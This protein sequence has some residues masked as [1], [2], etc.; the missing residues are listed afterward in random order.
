MDRHRVVAIGGS[1]GAVNDVKH[2]L[3][4]LPADL[5]AAVFIVVHV[6]AQGRNLLAGAFDGCGPL[7][8]TT[9]TDG[10]PVKPG[11]VYVAPA[12]QHLLV[13]DDVIRLGR[14]PREN[15]ARPSV[16]ALFRSVAL[17]Y[18]ARAIGLVI[19]GNLNDGAAGLAAIK[20]RGGVTAVQNPSDAVAPDMPL[21]ALE[22]SDVDYRAPTG[23]L[24][25]LL[26]SLAQQ[27]PGP[28]LPGSRALELEVDIALGR[29]C[30]STAIAEI[31]D[32]SPI[33]C[34]A[35]GGVL[36]EIK[37]PPL[38]YRC[39]VGHGY[40]GEA[41]AHEQ[42]GSIDEAVRV[43]LRI[44]DERATLTDRMAR[45]AQ[46]AGRPHSHRTLDD[47]T[48]ELRGYADVLRHAALKLME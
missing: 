43:A 32:V 14:G 16:D 22:A 46:A 13:V 39:Q 1:T 24:A 30:L 37:E 18:G 17:T 19:T 23:E 26:A 42:E 38:R 29:P 15:M 4:G 11:H 9:A 7:P 3:V 34:P 28:E 31:P 6:G 27:A 45:D 48:R 40:S 5:P 41:L 35:C 33:S 44:V 8:V 21:G 2:I 10:E 47:K 20:R 12:D 25:P 36:S